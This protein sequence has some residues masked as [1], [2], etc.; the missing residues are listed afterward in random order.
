MNGTY[1]HD[2][3]INTIVA[4]AQALNRVTF[5]GADWRTIGALRLRLALPL[6]ATSSTRYGPPI[7]RSR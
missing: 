2:Q 6:F 5:D 4:M 1:I 3:A 7:F